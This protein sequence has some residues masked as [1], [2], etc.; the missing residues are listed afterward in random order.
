MSSAIEDSCHRP[1]PA[2]AEG[3]DEILVDD[4]CISTTQEKKHTNHPPRR[5]ASLLQ[6]AAKMEIAQRMVVSYFH[7][8][9]IGYQYQFPSV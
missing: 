8:K 1:T 2:W 3:P 9:G 5:S 7:F 4:Y 6:L